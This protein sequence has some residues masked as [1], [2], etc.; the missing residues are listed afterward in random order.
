[1]KRNFSLLFFVL[2]IVYG[3]FA[4]KEDIISVEVNGLG[5]DD[6]VSN[7]RIKALENAKQ[8]ALSKAGITEDINSYSD[9]F[10]S[11]T[12]GSY[13]ELFAS[14]VFTNIRGSVSNVQILQE[15]LGI[16]SEK[17]IKCEI[18]ISCD[19]LK[20]KSLPDNMYKAEISGLKPFYFEGELLNW[21]VE[22]SKDSWMYVF[23]IP[24]NQNDAYFL[25]PNE[26]EK[27]FKLNSGKKYDF[28]KNV[29]Y[30]QF[31]DSDFEQADRIIFVFT[32]DKYPYTGDIT[33]KNIC[34][35]IFS[36]EPDQRI[37]ESFAVG[38]FP[39]PE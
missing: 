38:I 5:Y 25:F 37:V 19:V 24:Q 35:W 10:R 1:M 23:C 34:D 14:A 15:K 36:I 9:L 31:L 12:S 6:C 4:Q 3:V 17:L 13:Q 33:Y 11:E 20:Y 39:K 16:T 32:K 7:A 27:A 22:V 30:E 18:Q 8:E 28:P 29:K 26:W 2:F 21:S